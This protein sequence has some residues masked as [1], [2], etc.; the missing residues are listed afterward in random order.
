MQTLDFHFFSI[1]SIIYSSMCTH[2]GIAVPKISHECM[3]LICWLSFPSDGSC[4]NNVCV[5]VC[6]LLLRYTL[7]SQKSILLELLTAC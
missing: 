1:V 3:D 5:C 7:Y 2:K 6:A 4:Y